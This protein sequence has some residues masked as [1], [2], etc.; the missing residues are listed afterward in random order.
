MNRIYKYPLHITDRQSLLLAVGA[1]ILAAQFQGRELQLWVL[2]NDTPPH[3][4]RR[5]IAIYGTGNPVPENAGAYI[6]TAQDP[7]GLVWH[8]FDLTEGDP[9]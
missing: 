3:V 2:V 4:V 6:A 8:V 5:D 9:L 1:K 7:R